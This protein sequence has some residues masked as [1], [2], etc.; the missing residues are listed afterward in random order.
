MREPDNPATA[1]ETMLS[2][3]SEEHWRRFTARFHFHAGV[4]PE[5]WPAIDE[6]APSVTFDLAPV[7]DAEEPERTPAIQ[8]LEQHTLSALT[9]SFPPTG[10]LVVLDWQHLSH[11]FRPHLA[12]PSGG[13]E[14]PVPVFPN[15]DYHVFLTED[16]AD[17]VLG[18]PW[19]QSLCVFGS[20]LVVTL[21]PRLSSWLPVIRSQG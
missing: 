5:D 7:F 1:W 14:W 2:A 17:G 4:R 16:M 12:P 13:E 9:E 11:W 15:G 20:R 6:P 8:R 3:Q 19:E 18:H 21:V 10:R